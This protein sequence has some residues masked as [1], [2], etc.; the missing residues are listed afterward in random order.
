MSTL[1][2]AATPN[3]PK[4]DAWAVWRSQVRLHVT[5]TG[6]TGE[7]WAEECAT[8][9]AGRDRG[10]AI[11]ASQQRRTRMLWR[12]AGWQRARAQAVEQV[13]VK[14]V[15]CSCARGKRLTRWGSERER[16]LQRLE[17]V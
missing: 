3:E 15:A 4:R 13:F 5:L 12:R 11:A 7:R 6:T 14:V 10:G 9:A 1:G 17:G 2:I 8:E 16:E